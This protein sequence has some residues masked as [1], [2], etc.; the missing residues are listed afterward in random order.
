MQ[1]TRLADNPIITPGTP[2]TPGTPPTPGT[3]V[4]MGTN[5]NGPSLIR[6][7]DWLPSPLGRYYLYFAHHQGGFIRLAFA[8]DLAG[9]WRVHAPGTLALGQTPFDGH[10]ASPDVH[11]D[12][13][14]RRIVMYYHGCPREA[15]ADVPWRQYTCVATSADGRAFE[16]GDE[17]LCQSYLRVFTWRGRHLGIAMPGELYESADGLTGF[18][19]IARWHDLLCHPRP[20]E[21]ADFRYS[22]RHFAVR[23]DGDRLALYY[24]RIG[25]EPERIVCCEVAM[26]GDD[27]ASWRFAP[28]VSLLLPEHAWEGADQPLAPSVSGAS[29]E[30][31]RQLRDPAIYEEDGRA[32]L[33]YSVA[34]ERGIAIAELV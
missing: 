2:G 3:D 34:G 24:S 22:P 28:P 9:P 12:H 8:D 11:V 6:V 26:A 18:V 19:S 30:P 23:V 4:D 21:L 14:N 1:A 32:W 27:P 17:P 7:P 33:L 5:I 20:A 10:I 29:H 13:A 16:S 31:V 25:D 15:A